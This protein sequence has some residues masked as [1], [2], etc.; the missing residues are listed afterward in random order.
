ML[1]VKWTRNPVWR[2]MQNNFK[3]TAIPLQELNI[4]KRPLQVLAV[5]IGNR[6]KINAQTKYTI[7][8]DG[9]MSQD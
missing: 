2:L 3:R 4:H 7:Q 9:I 6:P 8:N 1:Q 5:P